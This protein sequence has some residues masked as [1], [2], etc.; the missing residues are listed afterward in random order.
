MIG[1][2]LRDAI[3]NAT[4][5]HCV[6]PMQFCADICVQLL[7]RATRSKIC[8]VIGNVLGKVC[9]AKIL[10][11]LGIEGSYRAWQSYSLHGNCTAAV[12]AVRVAGLRDTA[13]KST[14]V[15]TAAVKADLRSPMCAI[16]I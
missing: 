13:G 5:L 11:V 9:V 6:V 8:V 14:G 10:T 1:P 15:A 3:E 12:A 7:H 4:A 2:N 16:C